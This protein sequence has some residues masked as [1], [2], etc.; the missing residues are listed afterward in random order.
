MSKL[1]S[2]MIASRDIRLVQTCYPQI[3]QACHTR[4]VRAASSPHRL[5][6]R[7][8]AL[9]A[10]LDETRPIAPS[11]L[12]HHLGIGAPTMSAAVKRLVRLGYIERDC[13]PDDRRRV[14]LRL[15]T[16]GAAA[17]RASSVLEAGRVSRVLALLT[18][19]DRRAALNGLAL[20]ARASQESLRKDA[21]A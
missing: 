14:R 20:L 16:K 13:H 1:A 11:V 2:I 15:A 12:A 17:M 18:P 4:H 7:D 21:H 6:A 3:Y 19:A 8:S 9:L 5:S 10:H